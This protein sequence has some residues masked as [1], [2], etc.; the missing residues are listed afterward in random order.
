MKIEFLRVKG[1]INTWV[2]AFSNQDIMYH[3]CNI[4]KTIGFVKFDI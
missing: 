1:E 3:L 2:R 4:L